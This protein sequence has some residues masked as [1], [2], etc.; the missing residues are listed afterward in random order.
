M[1]QRT[2]I[3]SILSIYGFT[4]AA[5]CNFVTDNE[6]F[7]RW[8]A[9]SLINYDDVLSIAKNATRHTAPFSIGVLKLKCLTA[10]K[11]WIEN[12]TKM[13]ELH[14]TA[15]FIRAT[16]TVCINLYLAYVT[17]KDDN[18][19]FVDGPQLDKEDWVGFETRTFK[20]LDFFKAVEVFLYPI[21]SGM[22]YF[23]LLSMVLLY[24][25]PRSSGTFVS[26]V[27]IMTLIISLCGPI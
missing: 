17:V 18:I 19:K 11:F 5:Q 7:D 16:M 1:P 13:N 15:Q 21:S 23:V 26:L 9:F 22:T 4:T 3:G 14:V 6:G 24:G 12:K 25:K 8:T 2:A 27:L 10:L 20:C